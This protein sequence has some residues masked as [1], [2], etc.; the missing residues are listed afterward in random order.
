MTPKSFHALFRRIGRRTDL[1]VDVRP[2]LS[3]NGTGF[4]LANAG[5][6]HTIDSTLVRTPQHSAHFLY[7][8]LAPNRFKDFWK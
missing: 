3:R 1:G 8:E 6:R 2:H 4:A 7:T 5:P